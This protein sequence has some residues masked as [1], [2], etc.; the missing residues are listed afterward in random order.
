MIFLICSS[1][2]VILIL[3][4]GV[5]LVNLLLF[6]APVLIGFFYA[7]SKQ[8]FRQNITKEIFMPPVLLFQKILPF[9]AR[10]FSICNSC[11]R[12]VHNWL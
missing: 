8:R 7:E 12:K 9:L 2:L 1:F 5:E 4:S 11:I 3:L 6:F 10:N